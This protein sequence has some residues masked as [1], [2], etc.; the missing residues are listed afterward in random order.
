MTI[1]APNTDGINVIPA[2]LGPQVQKI[3]CPTE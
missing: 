3:A 2:K 1:T